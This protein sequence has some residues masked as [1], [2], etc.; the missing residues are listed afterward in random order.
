MAKKRKKRVKAARA[1]LRGKPLAILLALLA[2]GGMLGWMRTSA[3]IVHVRPAEVY[4]PD[5]P[6]QFDGTTALYLSDLNIR[7]ASDAASATRL[8]KKLAALEPDL[9]LLGG[10]YASGTLL[11]ALN[12]SEG[13]GCAHAQTFLRDLASFPAPLGKF[14][15]L[16]E[17]D[18][19]DALA[20]SLSIANVRLLRD[21]GAYIERDGAHIALVGLRDSSENA[22]DYDR[23]ARSFRREDCVLVLAHNPVAYTRIRMAEAQGGGAWADLVLSGHT[24]GGQI[25][26][27]GRTLRSFREEEA[28]RVSGW[29]Y[30]DD[31]PTLVCQGL[32]CRDVQLRLGT[33]S[34]VWLLTLRRPARAGVGS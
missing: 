13:D 11:D 14:A 16:G 7:S 26:L 22:T 32:G 3:A 25:Q 15:V 23:V 30:A 19:T 2:L 20:N 10:D 24:L 28:R 34:E 18:S 17:E 31:L 8:M 9:L 5:L 33:Q 12:Q 27:F 6:A 1:R 29:Y 21:S 4:I